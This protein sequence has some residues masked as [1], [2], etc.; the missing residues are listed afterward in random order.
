MYLIICILRKEVIFMKSPLYRC[1]CLT[2]IMWLILWGHLAFSG[3]NFSIVIRLRCSFGRKKNSWLCCWERGSARQSKAG[4]SSR[5]C[6][7]LRLTSVR[8][9]K[10]TIRRSFRA[11]PRC[12]IL[13]LRFSSRRERKNWSSCWGRWRSASKTRRCG[14]RP[15]KMPLI[16]SINMVLWRMAYSVLCRGNQILDFCPS[17]C[18]RKSRGWRGWWTLTSIEQGDMWTEFLLKDSLL[19]GTDI[20]ICKAFNFTTVNFGILRAGCHFCS[21]IGSTVRQSNSG[22]ASIHWVVPLWHE[23]GWCKTKGSLLHVWLLPSLGERK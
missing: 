12:W 3:I 2:A 7:L 11:Q 6:N 4:W 18:E 14:G 22:N 5:W 1:V 19:G 15:Q 10:K 16:T 8:I 9:T 17:R 20:S 21:S 23:V 13:D